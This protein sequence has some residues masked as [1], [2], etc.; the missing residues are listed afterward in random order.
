MKAGNTPIGSPVLRKED[1]RLVT[2]QGRFSDDVN[3]AGQGYAVFVRSPHAHARIVSIDTA[4]AT[5]VPGVILALTGREMHEDGLK[6]LPH[7]PKSTHRAETP[8]VNR[9]GSPIFV[10]PHYP[11]AFDKAR[12][13]GEAVAVVVAESAYAAKDGAEALEVNYE[14]LPAVTATRAT[15]EADAPHVWE[16]AASNVCMD[17]EVGNRD[18]TAA[19]FAKA[20]HVVKLE[21]WAQRVTGVP[22]EPRSAVAAY[23]PATGRYTLHAGSGGAVRLKQDL[24]TALGIPGDQVRVIMGDVGGN[25]GTRGEIYPEFIIVAWAARRAG[26]PVKWT[27]ERHEAFLSDYQGRDLAVTAELALDAEG[28]FL[29]MRGSNIGNAGAHTVSYAPLKKGLGIMSSIYRVPAAHFR[30]RAVVSNTMSTRPYRSAG[31]PEVMYV[32]ERLI[33]LAARQCHFDRIE[34]R[35][36]NLLTEAELPY[37][38]Q[39]HMTYDNGAYHAAM[40]RALRLGNWAGFERRRAESRNKRMCRGIGVAN[41][42]D[43]STGAPRE[44]ADVTVHAD[45]YVDVVIGVV[46]NGQG[47]ET[48]F[49][50]LVTGWLGVPFENV[51]L[52]TGDTDIV[53]VGGGTHG[54]RGLRMGSIVIWNAVQQIIEKGKRIAARLLE[55]EPSGIQFERGR[56]RAGPS[57][58]A[59]SLIEVASAAVQ[60][61]DLPQELRGPLAASSEEAHHAASFPYG[62]H[63]CEV[64]IDPELGTVEIVG[65][66]AVDDVGRAV[67]PMII[68]GQIHGG[69]AQGVGQALLEQCFYDSSSGQ[70]LSGSLMDYALPR[71]DTFPFF[72]TAISEVPSTT[73]PLGM[74]PAGESG[75]TPALGVVVN[76]IVDALAEYGVEHIE[77]PATPERI[78]RAIHKKPPIPPSVPTNR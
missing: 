8:L 42:V 43:T 76:A 30:A 28:S 55:I 54:G 68:H 59:A 33:D 39:F 20:K 27:C 16:E 73:H 69:I 58:R 26:R 3:L 34:L 18:A 17:A 77:M 53:K 29:A 64:E 48:T 9:D 46:P 10:A 5:R 74:R 50:Q 44:R 12:Y 6:P 13:V 61:A 60:S 63:V 51:R 37:T 71:A 52:I 70:L 1:H 47:H 66:A 36:R 7:V 24:A 49:A 23:E 31:R 21:T 22:L 72:K 25:F 65:Y 75:T 15:A 32:M 41:Y 11:L 2:G 4:A 38:N 62:C 56:F 35:R 67:N 14:V 78:W 45:G 57:D 40:D 19:A